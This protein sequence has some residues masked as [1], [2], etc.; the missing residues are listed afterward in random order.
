MVK[1]GNTEVIAGVKFAVGTPYPD[2]PDEDL[3]FKS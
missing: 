1:L 2:S 3:C